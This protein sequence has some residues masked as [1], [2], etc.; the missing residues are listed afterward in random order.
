M[1]NA[2]IAREG[3]IYILML[4][5]LA[6]VLALLGLKIISVLI[7]ALTLFIIFFCDLKGS[8]SGFS[9]IACRRVIE[10]ARPGTDF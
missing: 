7:V 3:F 10:I 1:K 5:L 2:R 8:P 4:A 6:W 9:V